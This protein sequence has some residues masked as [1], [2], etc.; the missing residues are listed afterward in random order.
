[1]FVLAQRTV[2]AA[3]RVFLLALDGVTG[4]ERGAWDLQPGGFGAGRAAASIANGV[5]YAPVDSALYAVHAPAVEPVAS[6]NISGLTL[7][8]AFSPAIHDY[9][10]WCA[11]GPNSV[12]LSMTAEAGGTVRV[13]APFQTQPRPSRTLPL[14]LTGNQAVVVEGADAGGATA[15][16]WIRCLP[17]DFPAI[18][19]TPHPAAGEPTPGWYIAG[20][21]VAPAGTGS[22][23]V[24]LDRHGTPVWYKRSP[25]GT[26]NNVHAPRKNTVIFAAQPVRFGFSVDPNAT[27]TEY[28][29]DTGQVR[30]FKT[31]GVPTDF[32][33]LQSLP[34][35][36]VLLMSYPFVSGVDLTGLPGDPPP[37]EDSTIADC[38]I[39]EVTPDGQLV[40]EWAASEHSDVVAE[41]MQPT[42]I[43]VN[44]TLI[45]DVFHCNSIDVAPSG[46]VLVSHRHLNA[47]YLISRTTGNVVWKIGGKPST[48][49][50]GTYLEIT[51][52]SLAFFQQH[53]A[54]LLPNG[55]L[56]VFDN[57]NIGGP[58]ARG[59][60]YALD[61]DAGTAE[62]VF[63]YLNPNARPS[64][65]TGSFR[66]YS[67]GHSVIGWG[68]DAIFSGAVLT[69]IDADSDNVLDIAFTGPNSSYRGLK[70]PPPR[71]DVNVLR[72]TAGH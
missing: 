33:D 35:G 34:N 26:A 6:L 22:Y 29:L 9:V 70:V 2:A 8:P 32:H 14:T 51:N 48:P 57:Q 17:S 59:L 47:L 54:R 71:L 1:V 65:A 67:D 23:A 52:D 12:T 37:G 49:D 28:T 25:I 43:N 24:I 63:E 44:G 18:T 19:A 68:I 50:G 64:A 45:Y 46:D 16:Y 3:N 10:L 41:N 69:E 15:Q 30:N 38:V 55:N 60:E 66:R 39:Q 56:T 36:N 20:N 58:P 4:T 40:W 61:V 31:V 62:K 5:V 11:A 42:P 7:S 53:D 27:F 72:L 21:L 13:I